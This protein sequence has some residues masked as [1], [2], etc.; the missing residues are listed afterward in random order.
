MFFVTMFSRMF[1]RGGRH[2]FGQSTGPR[3][4][5]RRNRRGGTM[6]RLFSSLLVAFAFAAVAQPQAPYPN[7]PIKFIVADGP[8]SVSDLRARQISVKL[9]EV[10]GQPV[11]VENRVGGSMMIGAEAAA[12]SPPDGYTLFFGNIVTHSLN[13]MLFKSLPYKPE[14]FTPVTSVSAGPLILVVHPDLGVKTV[15]EFIALAKA[16]PGKLSY[17]V[18]G[19]GSPGHIV[20]EQ[21]KLQRG[22]QMEL[23]AYKS[24]AQATQDL[25]AGHLKISL[26]YWSIVGPQVRAGKLRALAVASQKRLDVA[27]EV[28]TFAEVGMP[29]VEAKGWQGLMVPVGT[30]RPIIQRLHAEVKKVL[31]TPE[32]RSQILDTGAEIGGETPEEFAAFIAADRERWKKWI[33]DAGI[34]PN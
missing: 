22:T 19:Q 23:V 14:E 29:G 21:I 34:Q 1:G 32:I 30:P 5:I 18:V 28:P 12:R 33:T 8:G 26:S 10:L 15:D 31:A 4:T 27:P 6:L 2:G 25:I 20:M 11:V 7:K 3:L 17:G 13:P 24:S 16:Q 9:G